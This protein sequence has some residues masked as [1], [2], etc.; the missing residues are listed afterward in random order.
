MTVLLVCDVYR[1]ILK[2]KL[3]SENET[4]MTLAPALLYG[5]NHRLKSDSTPTCYRVQFT[6][7]LIQID[8]FS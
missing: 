6:H 8:F 7:S 4:Q 1:W 3:I 2:G 5:G